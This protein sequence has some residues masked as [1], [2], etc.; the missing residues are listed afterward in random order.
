VREQHPESGEEVVVLLEY[1]ERQ[2]DEP[3]LQV[4]R[5]GFSI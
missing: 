1:L 3:M 5:T 2:L 4:E